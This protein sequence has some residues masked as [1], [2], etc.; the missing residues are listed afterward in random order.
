M[1]TRPTCKWY[2]DGK[3]THFSRRKRCH[4][5]DASWFIY[6]EPLHPVWVDQV[7][8]LTNPMEARYYKITEADIEA[9]RNGKILTITSPSP[10]FIVFMGEEQDEGQI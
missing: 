4:P 1:E 7:C 5:S 10:F 8:E 9:L 2:R 3:C 6:P